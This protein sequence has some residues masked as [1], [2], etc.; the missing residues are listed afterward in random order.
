[1]KENSNFMVQLII[2]GIP[3]A[4]YHSM[5]A[6]PTFVQKETIQVAV[7]WDFL[8]INVVKYSLK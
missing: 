7:I 1:M 5:N 2:R 4:Q 8:A 6:G 3:S